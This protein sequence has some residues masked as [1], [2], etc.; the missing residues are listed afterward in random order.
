MN[1]V[2]RLICF[3]LLAHTT[4][5]AKIVFESPVEIEE[6]LW[7]E[8]TGYSWSNPKSR[9]PDPSA[10]S[11][12]IYATTK[13]DDIRGLYAT[14]F[15]D[16][17]Y[18]AGVYRITFDLAIT[19]KFAYADRLPPT[20]GFAANLGNCESVKK[21]AEHYLVQNIDNKVDHAFKLPE[22][23]AA[24]EWREAIFEIRIHKGSLLIGQK[25]GFFATF[26]TGKDGIN[27]GFAFD[28]FTLEYIKE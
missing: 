20:I 9:G 3:A 1:T 21:D 8:I 26:H 10:G 27:T 2:I 12:Y 7:T 19:K 25:I 6:Q 17:T 13:K 4:M 22:A 28:Q 15:N 16:I 5:H 14:T 24:H 23:L 11:N 18:K